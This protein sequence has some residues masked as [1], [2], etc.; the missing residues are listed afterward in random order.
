MVDIQKIRE[1]MVII[2]DYKSLPQ[3][4]RLTK[5]EQVEQQHL[6]QQS[7]EKMTKTL[8]IKRQQIDFKRN[9]LR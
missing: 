4:E 3:L 2:Q 6:T 7:V 8:V 1:D 9:N 5:S